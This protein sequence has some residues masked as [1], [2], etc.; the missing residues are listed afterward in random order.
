MTGKKRT[1]LCNEVIELAKLVRDIPQRTW[2]GYPEKDRQE[3]KENLVYARNFMK[4]IFGDD[5]AS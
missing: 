5:H 2:D 4:A 3:A 1:E